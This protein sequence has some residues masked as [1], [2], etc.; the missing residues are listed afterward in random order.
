MKVFLRTTSLA[1]AVA[2]AGGCASLVDQQT[3]VHGDWPTYNRDVGGMRYSPLTQITPENVSQLQ[4]AWSYSMRTGN[5]DRVGDEEVA[6]QSETAK[7]RSSRFFVSQATPLVVNGVMYLPTPYGQVVAL[8]AESGKEIWVYQ[9]TD[10]DQAA[11]RGVAYWPGAD[12]ARPSIIFGTRRGRLISLDA[13]TGRPVDGFGQGGVVDMKTPEVLNGVPYEQAVLGMSSPPLVLGNLVITG[14]R[15]QEAP[16]KGPAGD[17][18]AW[19]ARTGKLVWTFHTVPREGE[20]G[21]ETWAGDSWRERSGVNVWTF[22]VA[23]EQRGIVYLPIGAPTFDRWGGDREGINLYSN[24]VVAVEAATGKYLWH[25]QTVHHDI[26]DLDLPALLLVDV[27]KNG[28]VIPA[29]GTM[30]K[31]GL[32]F[33]LDRVTG[34]PI[35]EVKEVPVPTDTDVPD[36]KPWPTQPVPTAPPPLTRLSFKLSELTDLTPE[37]REKCEALVEKWNVVDSKMYQPLRVDSSVASFPGSWGGVDWGGA[38]FDPK[39]GILVVN[40]NA[41]ASPQQLEK[42]PDGSYGL[43]GGYRYFWDESLR[44]PCQNPPWGELIGVNVN[45]GT[46]AWR[47]TLGVSDNLPEDK[48]NTGRPGLG[49]PISTA[50]GITFIGAT[51]DG[52]FRAFDSRSGRLLWE[53]KLK[54]S[55]YATPMTFQGRS[56]K[57]YVAVVNTGGVGG[58]PVTNDEVTVFALP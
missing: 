58:Q 31:M 55:A 38:S 39:L 54:A 17:V 26:W 3:A 7:P 9:L 13:E 41:L 16:T 19:D 30:N 21:N 43:K 57:Q 2:L 35:Y 27:R 45:N 18:R 44:M 6:H 5:V 36:E 53:T 11:M 40:T 28:K 25:F 15:V 34:E 50:S 29:V 10:S 24:S 46:I 48:R 37:I 8:D 14:S 47:S 4:V 23:D 32:L 33:L 12:G 56:G 51:D 42:K 52:R 1:V 22:P 49:G 20:P